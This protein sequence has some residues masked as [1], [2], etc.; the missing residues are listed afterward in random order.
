MQIM[1]RIF[2][3]TVLV[4]IFNNVNINNELNIFEKHEKRKKQIQN[5]KGKL[6]LSSQY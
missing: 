2:V 4:F 6:M 3:I 5:V 1:R